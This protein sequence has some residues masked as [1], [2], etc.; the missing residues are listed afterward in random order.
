MREAALLFDLAAVRAPR[1]RLVVNGSTIASV[2]TAE[3][4]SNNHYAADRFHVQL[5]LGDAQPAPWAATD[6]MEATLDLSLDG[7]L[8]WTTVI[9]GIVDSVDIDPLARTVT[10]AGRDRTAL[11]IE[12]RTQETF[13]NR[14]ASEIA[15]LLAARH[16]L[17]P[18]VAPTTEL[19]G[20][21]WQ[22][23]HDRITLGEFAHAITEWDLLV[24][25]ARREGFDVWVSGRTL[26]FRPPQTAPTAAAVLRPAPM[27]G[28]PANVTSLQLRR[29]LTFARDIEVVVKSWNAHHQAAFT[30]TAR[31]RRKRGAAGIGRGQT[32]QMQ[33]YVYII[34]NLTPDAALKLAQA[35]LAELSRNERVI[36]AEMPGELTLAP[37][38]MMRLEG[39]FTD[40]DQTY[41][42]DEIERHIDIT[43]GFTQRLSARNTEVGSQATG[44]T[45][46]VDLSA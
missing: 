28:G 29:A 17:T 44:P 1:L 35:K 20:R 8:S 34:P 9:D 10:L 7:G 23:E 14:R 40:F 37:R 46:A 36:S 31:A 11:L 32:A 13:A 18:D 41:W 6:D 22:D 30:Q 15:E 2:V 5:A 33:R 19:V 4:V 43:H 26:H 38:M 24:T 3:L 45:D 25:L 39:T 42:I 16:G 21:Y 12:A 27:T